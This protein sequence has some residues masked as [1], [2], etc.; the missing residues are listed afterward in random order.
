M[1]ILQFILAILFLIWIVCTKKALNNLTWVG[2]RI[3]DLKDK[4]KEKRAVHW[5]KHCHRFGF[6]LDLF[7]LCALLTISLLTLSVYKGAMGNTVDKATVIGLT[8]FIYCAFASVVEI[9][10]Q[11]NKSWTILSFSL[12]LLQ[13]IYYL[14]TP[15]FWPIY[16][17]IRSAEASADDEE[18]TVEDEIL[19]LVEQD[20]EDD[21]SGDA[22]LE[23]DERKMIQGIFDLNNT[24]V[25]EVM[26]P[27]VDITGADKSSTVE[28]VVQLIIETGH[29]RLPV[30]EESIDQIIGIIYAKDLLDPDKMSQSIQELLHKPLYIPESKNI[31]DLLDELR[32]AKQH[33]AVIIDEYGGTSGLITIE[34]IIEEIV[35]EIQDEFDENE[36]LIEHKFNADGSIEIE[37]RLNIDE[38]NELLKTSIEE[39]DDFDTIAGYITDHLGRIPKK[40]E[41]LSIDGYNFT[42][43]D[44][45]ERRIIT[46]TVTKDE[47]RD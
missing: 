19:S 11:L 41:V 4:K 37:G 44:A 9:K 26:T 3:L 10:L 27:R 16:I 32:L 39:D 36:E 38:F 1:I 15:L 14:S 43:K 28:E 25:R 31:G 29:S 12:P 13:I 23:A 22:D 6:L 35:G 47:E 34:D 17:L 24:F 21:K 18:I 42:I 8:A 40:G 5:I 20:A 30:Y 45:D 7:V 2:L 46:I 33:M